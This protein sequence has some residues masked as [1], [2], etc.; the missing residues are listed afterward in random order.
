MRQSTPVSEMRNSM[1]VEETK[2]ETD[3][4][5]LEVFVSGPHGHK[6]PQTPP[7]E[8]ESSE[9]DESVP[10]PHGKETPRTPEIR[11]QQSPD[12][13]YDHLDDWPIHLGSLG[14]IRRTRL[15]RRRR[16]HLLDDVPLFENVSGVKLS[17]VLMCEAF[18]A[19]RVETKTPGRGELKLKDLLSDVT[20][21]ARMERMKYEAMTI[22]P[23]HLARNTGKDRRID[24]RAI[25]TNKGKDL[26]DDFQP[27]CRIVGEGFPERCAE[28]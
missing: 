11:P 7:V 28:K 4:S 13:E 1:L 14:E 3:V 19:Q 2:S 18:A 16:A 8:P 23:P 24:A 26:S 21:V 25:W 17:H 6:T 27:K 10:A 12:E 22:G 15:A 5:E 9:S 20:G